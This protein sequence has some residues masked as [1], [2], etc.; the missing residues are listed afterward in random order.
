ML[1]MLAW[2]VFGVFLGS[3]LTG[4]LDWSWW[5]VTAPLWIYA[6]TWF[7]VRFIIEFGMA[8]A[9]EVRKPKESGT[10]HVRSERVG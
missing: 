8:V 6:V 7:V 9:K 2:V 10:R 3:K 5:L 4:T 1:N